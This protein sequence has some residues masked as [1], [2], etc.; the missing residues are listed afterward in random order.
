MQE[1][2][3]GRTRWGRFTAVS[4]V[5]GVAIAALGVALAQGLL[6]ASFNVNNK[7]FQIQSAGLEGSGFGAIMDSVTK[8][9]ADG[10]TA[11]QAVARAGFQTAKLN[12]LCAAVHQNVLGLP[13]T[14]RISAGNPTDSVTDITANDLILD[15]ESVKAN[16]T[17]SGLAL[18]KSADDVKMGTS[19]ESLGGTAGNF[20]LQAG[21]ANL[22][23]LD[24]K[25]F[26]TTIAGSIGLSN[27]ALGI[28]T[29]SNNCT[30]VP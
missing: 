19:A 16:A 24:A 17:M 20:G 1:N 22:N 26:G 5:S 21:T 4:A 23:G 7:A 25:A 13:F 10:T 29:G 11:G 3:V 15:G 12:G 9:N 14:L 6:A 28:E 8:D 18:G 30:I 27:L 2:A